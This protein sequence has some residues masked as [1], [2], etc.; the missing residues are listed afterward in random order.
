MNCQSIVC[1]CVVCFVDIVVVG[2]GG[3]ATVIMIAVVFVHT[4]HLF[5]DGG[6]ARS[7]RRQSWPDH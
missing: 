6:A 4:H 1:A 5:R 3:E 7:F 2:G